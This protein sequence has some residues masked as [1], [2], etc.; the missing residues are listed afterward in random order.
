MARALPS[1]SKQAPV[2]RP[3]QIKQQPIEFEQRPDRKISTPKPT[4]FGKTP[5]DLGSSEST[6][7]PQKKRSDLPCPPP[8]ER[9]TEQLRKDTKDSQTRVAKSSG[10][11]MPYMEIS[12]GLRWKTRYHAPR[13][14]VLGDIRLNALANKIGRRTFH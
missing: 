10:F 11:C 3:S 7:R 4:G 1:K 2:A 8:N 12:V 5:G 9:P 13:Q 6:L 14:T